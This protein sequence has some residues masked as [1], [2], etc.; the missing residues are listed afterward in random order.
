MDQANVYEN[1]Q[2]SAVDGGYN[3]SLNSAIDN[4]T[5]R[6]VPTEEQEQILA[7]EEALD[8]I[9]ADELAEGYGQEEAKMARTHNQRAAATNRTQQP[10]QQVLNMNDTRSE[11][12]ARHNQHEDGQ[13]YMDIEDE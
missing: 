13:R 6:I 8:V 4:N 11:M 10:S 5:N 3:P 7:N 12:A 2:R 1:E 9:Q